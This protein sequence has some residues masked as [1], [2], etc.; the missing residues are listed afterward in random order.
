MI[1]GPVYKVFASVDKV[2]CASEDIA[3]TSAT[4]AGAEFVFGAIPV[5]H[6]ICFT[7]NT[8]TAIPAQTFK[9]GADL[10][11]KAPA[12]TE[13]EGKIDLGSFDRD[14]TTLRA[15]FAE[16]PAGSYSGT[17]NLMNPSTNDATFTTSCLTNAATN[18]RVAGNGGTVKAGQGARFGIGS[19]AGLNCPANTRGVE[20]IFTVPQG[21]VIGSVVRQ[22]STTGQASAD[23]MIGSSISPNAV[24]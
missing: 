18:G 11:P 4:A 12:T 22:D 5:D 23:A 6:A 3:A 20:L 14:G 9:I 16:V 15:A 24:P 21:S 17:V 8:T 19:A 13:D 1:A 2:A 10:V 7:A